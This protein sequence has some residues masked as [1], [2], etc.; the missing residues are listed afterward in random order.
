MPLA[1]AAAAVALLQLQ[2]CAHYVLPA[3]RL[4]TPE[5]RG[6]SILDS[7]QTDQHD[8]RLSRPFGRVEGGMLM[9]IDLIEE[10][11]QGAADAV[12]GVVPKP[13][14]QPATIAALGFV[15][16]L[17][18]R[19]DLGIR[20][21]SHAPFSFRF[22]YQL[23]GEPELTAKA[24]NF[25]TAIVVS[26]GILIGTYSGGAA[27]TS[28]MYFSGD[29]S[30]IAGYRIWNRHLFSL[31]P[32]ITFGSLS[33]VPET[34]ADAVHTGRTSPSSASFSQYGAGL[35]Y[36]YSLETLFLRGEAT[37]TLGAIGQT[38]LNGIHFG[39]LLGLAL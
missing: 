15:A 14:A 38:Q 26:P 6:T 2:G 37:Y 9:G 4:E 18:D 25:S 24:G 17:S 34:A 23:S 19:I 32:F 3:N 11:Y 13:E 8:P 31:A 16:G 28:T 30:F 39:A 21:T 20:V 35:G 12:T 10:P 5:A 36:Q 1:Q 7:T 33:G 27:P 29:I 22:K